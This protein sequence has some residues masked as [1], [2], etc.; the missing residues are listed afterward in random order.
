M[1]AVSVIVSI[2][3]AGSAYAQG[4]AVVIT[5]NQRDLSVPTYVNATV[6]RVDARRHFH[7][8]IGQQLGAAERRDHRRIHDDGVGPRDGNPRLLL[9]ATRGEHCV[10]RP[11]VTRDHIR[12]ARAG[13]RSVAELPPGTTAPIQPGKRLAVARAVKRQRV[14]LQSRRAKIACHEGQNGGAKPSARSERPGWISGRR[15]SKE[16]ARVIVAPVVR[17][18]I[19]QEVERG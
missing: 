17:G 14:E 1:R 19:R 11:R 15:L 4:S 5:P 16:G 10:I 3:L 12:P 18:E 13:I 2:V 8:E 6:V 7:P 9:K